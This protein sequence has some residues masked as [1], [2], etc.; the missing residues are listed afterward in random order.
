MIEITYKNIH[1]EETKKTST[2]KDA[3]EIVNTGAAKR[4][5]HLIDSRMKHVVNVDRIVSPIYRYEVILCVK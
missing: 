3:L 2:E 4:M 5:P 1:R